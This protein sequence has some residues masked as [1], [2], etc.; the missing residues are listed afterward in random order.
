MKEGDL[1]LTLEATRN[2]TSRDRHEH[3]IV[4]RFSSLL[5]GQHFRQPR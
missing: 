2:G 4:T 3:D 1:I 5:G